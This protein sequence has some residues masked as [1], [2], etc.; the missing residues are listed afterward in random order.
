MSIFN[1]LDKQPRSEKTE[2]VFQI[3]EQQIHDYKGS[4]TLY[5]GHS[6]WMW[7]DGEISKVIYQEKGEVELFSSGKIKQRRTKLVVEPGA[8]YTQ[9]LN[10]K[11]AKRR[12][13]QKGLF[14]KEEKS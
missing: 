8:Y 3:N 4:E 9:A 13:R 14:L 7:K 2:K 1:L 10:L 12:F 5:R 11:N 6:L